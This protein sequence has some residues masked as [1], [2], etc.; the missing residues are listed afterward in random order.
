MEKKLNRKK[1]RNKARDYFHWKKSYR[2]KGHQEKRLQGKNKQKQA[3]RTAMDRSKR[4]Y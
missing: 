2:E 3:R 4:D 1:L